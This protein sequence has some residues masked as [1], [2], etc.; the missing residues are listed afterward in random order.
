MLLTPSASTR[1]MTAEAQ[2][3][4]EWQQPSVFLTTAVASSRKAEIRLR[5]QHGMV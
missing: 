2:H 1:D 3:V 5:L 4:G